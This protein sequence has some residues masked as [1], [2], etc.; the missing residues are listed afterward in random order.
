MARAR[1]EVAPGGTTSSEYEGDER[2]AA[3]L[4]M[5]LRR[6]IMLWPDGFAWREQTDETLR[7]AEVRR[8][9]AGDAPRIGTLE[10]RLGASGELLLVQALP[11]GAQQP[12]E[13][14]RVLDWRRHGGRAW[15]RTIELSA[16]G[17]LVWREVVEEVTTRV[18]YVD[19]FFRPA[20]RRDPRSAVVDG[21]L[22]QWIDLTAFTYAAHLLPDGASWDEALELGR[23]WIRAAGE[24][25]AGTPHAVD[26]VPCF[27]LSEAGAPT[28][29]LV[30]LA[31]AVVDP[32]QGWTTRGDGPGLGTLLEGLDELTP[33]AVATLREAAAEEE[34][35]GV[36]YCRIARVE[37]PGGVQLYRP[38]RNAP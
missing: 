20:D 34:R 24:E 17:Q 14:L 22:V 33:G 12:T 35:G 19:T 28:R 8:R 10:A 29:C 36:P 6:A 18:F 2:D 5:E 16:R 21:I 7:S 1:G 26:P 37:G 15:P 25:L 32:P 9:D 23:A 13:S 4:Q 3:L 31:A 11:L 27:E 30:R 38:L